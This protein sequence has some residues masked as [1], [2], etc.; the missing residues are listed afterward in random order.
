M[1]RRGQ[2]FVA[3]ALIAIGAG[4][5]S[6]LP[7]WFTLDRAAVAR[8]E[9]WRLWTGHL[10]HGS[11]T[12]YAYDVGAAALLCVTFGPPKRLL[13][14]APLVSVTL[15]AALPAV[16][17][18]YGLSAVLHAWVV[19]LATGLCKDDSRPRALLA[20]S[21]LVGTIVKALVET[22]LG[23]SVF[24]SDLDFGGPVLHASHLV[25]ALIGLVPVVIGSTLDRLVLYRAELAL[26]SCPQADSPS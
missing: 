16:Q 7:E 21:L 23:E 17:H 5:A 6:A 4:A 15:L 25:G 1:N 2:S 22:T 9:V 3:L 18:Y 12:H 20:G 24:T 10:V 13:W 19:V 8:G 14:I 26:R 11:W